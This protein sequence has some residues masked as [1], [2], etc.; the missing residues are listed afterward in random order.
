MSDS[1][2]NTI[3]KFGLLSLT[4][5]AVFSFNN[6]INNN[7]EI[8]L[9][10]APM[11]FLATIF[12]FIPFCLIIAEF[13]S[14]NKN[15]EAGVYAWVK[16]SLGGRWAFISAYTYWFVN[17]FFFTS[18]LPRVIAYASYAFLGYEYIFTPLATTFL[19]MVLFAFAT[20][21]ST[22]GAKLLGPITSVTSS[23]ML[24]LTLSYILLAGVALVGGVQPADP[25]TVEVMVPDFSWAFLGITTWIFMAAGGAES[26]AVYVND[27]KG[28]SKSFV[29]VI[30][31]AGLFIGVLYS[32]A[33]LLINVFVH[34]DT[35]KF[36]GGSV[37]V[38]EGLAA[39]FGLPTV[40]MNRFVGLVSFTAMFG[41]L[42]MWTATPVKIFFSEIPA[43]IFGKKTVELNENG[44][45][46]RAAWIQYLIVLPLMVIPTLGS[47]TAQDLMNTVI[48]MTAAASM[49][50]PLFIM[51]AYLNL[52]LKLDHL[53]RDFRMGSR[54]TGIAVV[55][56]LIAI[57][58]VGFL[59]STFPTGADIMTIIFYNVGGIVIFLGFAW[60]KYNRYEASL[61]KEA[62]VKE[63]LPA[64][65]VSI[66]PS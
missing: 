53:P 66:Q 20:Y 13:V 5:A 14:L 37:Q 50:P 10:S 4:F 46:A 36:T 48:N 62:R 25:I 28:G 3:G 39:H 49:L 35:L 51:L 8:G 1:K 57:F 44:V 60:W 24:L 27:V 7:I 59:A 33:S 31:V 42:L 34:S 11:F 23:L 56:V 41:S 64:A 52:R 15:S 29:K 2:R 43:G 22:N 12:Y 18:L 30:I 65:Q 61:S 63:A 9:A 26:V 21:V 55:S 19:S 32:I 47:N 58:S 6:V 54:T 16:S 40:L 17:L 45:P 38:F